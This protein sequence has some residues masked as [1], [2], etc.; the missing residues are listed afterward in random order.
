MSRLSCPAL[1][2]VAC[3]TF[4]A[5]AEAPT[6]L[7]DQT[8]CRDT[9]FDEDSVVVAM[10]RGPTAETYIEPGT[11]PLAI[12]ID[13]DVA[14]R[15]AADRIQVELDYDPAA[16]QRSFD[17]VE[18]CPKAILLSELTRDAPEQEII[19]GR[20]SAF[21][22]SAFERAGRIFL[23]HGG[24]PVRLRREPFVSEQ[25]KGQNWWFVFEPAAG[26]SRLLI[27]PVVLDRQRITIPAVPDV[28]GTAAI[29]QTD[30]LYWD[31]S[32][33]ATYAPSG[34]AESWRDVVTAWFGALVVGH[35]PNEVVEVESVLLPDETASVVDLGLLS[36]LSAEVATVF[37]RSGAEPA[38]G[39]VLVPCSATA[40]DVSPVTFAR[41]TI[42]AVGLEH[43]VGVLEALT[44]PV[45]CGPDEELLEFGVEVSPQNGRPAMFRIRLLFEEGE[46]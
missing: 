33:R 32:Q 25:A 18:P 4:G 7:S 39:S 1:W 36:E 34:F 26:S 35:E 29:V 9:Q 46:G 14:P 37:L 11:E 43:E 38:A 30:A 31:G 41:A 8:A 12:A 19:A 3:V 17:V 24:S 15:S 13:Y 5:C 23:S 16:T 40:I 20:V 28:P 44:V 10:D 21:A 22:G 45:S 42:Q 2:L 27:A 6:Q